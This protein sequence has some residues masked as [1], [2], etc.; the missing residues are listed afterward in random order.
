MEGPRIARS[1]IVRSHHAE[2]HG[3]GS[4]A[5]CIS[6][7][8]DPRIQGNA[9]VTCSVFWILGCRMLCFDARVLD[10]T[11]WSAVS[12]Q[13]PTILHPPHW[14]LDPRIPISWFATAF[15]KLW[16]AMKYVDSSHPPRNIHVEFTRH[17]W[18]LSG[19]CYI[20]YELELI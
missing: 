8:W 19:V 15:P 12:C 2:V 16:S 10:P 1:G 14:L 18:G 4:S 5:S 20:A 7:C 13:Y 6:G 11:S 3:S 9:S 17:H